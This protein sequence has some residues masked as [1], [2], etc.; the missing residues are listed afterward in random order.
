MSSS[1][2]LKPRFLMMHMTPESRSPSK[3]GISQARLQKTVGKWQFSICWCRNITRSWQTR[4]SM[5]RSF[6]HASA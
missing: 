6:L 1:I 4:H 3:V 2:D 5:P